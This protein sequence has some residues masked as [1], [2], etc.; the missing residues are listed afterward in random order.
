M[1]DLQLCIQIGI[2]SLS[3]MFICLRRR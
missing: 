2:S 1:F 3:F